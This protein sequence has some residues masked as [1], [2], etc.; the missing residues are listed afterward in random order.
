[1][2]N[3]FKDPLRII[4][5]TTIPLC[6]SKCEWAAF[7]QKKGAVKLHL[8]ID[9]DNLLPVDAYLTDG[10]THE[11]N[12]ML[13]LCQESGVLY[14]MDR[15]YVDYKSLYSIELNGAVFV[16]RM[17]SNGSYQRVKNI[18]HENSGQVISDV[19]IELTGSVTKKHYPKPLRKVKYHDE[20]TNRTYEFITNNFTMT[21][22]EVA[23][24]YKERWQIELFFKW[25][26]QNL[27]IKTFWGTSQNAVFSQIWVALILSVL[28]WICKLAEG[29]TDT[30][31]A[32]LQKLK[33]TLLTKQSIL[34]ICTPKP[35]PDQAPDIQPYFEV[36]L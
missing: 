21:A 31:H 30:A 29:I 32:L 25:L 4:D 20:E 36:F 5:A 8:G 35:P 1:M 6:L 12:R 27:K 11:I 19:V 13:H 15:G 18:P 7:R 28:L 2:K 24:I 10:K 34:D 14:V 17:K 16:T 22:D 33:T 23:K 26:K 3:Q 9:G